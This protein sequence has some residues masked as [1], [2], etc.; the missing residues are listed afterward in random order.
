MSD[1]YDVPLSPEAESFFAKLRPRLQRSL[2][3]VQRI[4]VSV[5]LWGPSPEKTCPMANMRK[6]LRR[7]LRE[8]GHAA[9]FSEE[10]WDPSAD[11]SL[12]LQQLVQAQNFDLVVSLPES[13]GA[14]AEVHDFA[15]DRRVNAKMLVLL[16]ES[17]LDGYG[18]KS[19]TSISSVLSCQILTYPDADC[20]EMIEDK[21]LSEVQ[22]IREIKYM[23][24]GGKNMGLESL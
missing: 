19:L 7:K 11:S 22:R 10:L 9:F 13:A 4:P 8:K 15:S 2:A 12:R 6:G 1:D 21:V 23:L 3:E 17:T 18:A 14:I 5:L 20:V 24:F 16:D